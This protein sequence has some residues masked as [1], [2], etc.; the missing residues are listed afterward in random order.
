MLGHQNRLRYGRMHVLKGSN[1]S[2][3]A[4][5]ILTADVPC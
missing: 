1:L 3:G 2:S 5:F 4:L